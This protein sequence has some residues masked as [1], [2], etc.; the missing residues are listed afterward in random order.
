MLVSSHEEVLNDKYQRHILR[1]N[2]RM[3]S[4]WRTPRQ[5]WLRL[6]ADGSSWC[7]NQATCEGLLINGIGEWVGGFQMKIESTSTKISRDHGNKSSPVTT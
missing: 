1:I 5:G 2:D 4:S 7:N 3:E 6:D